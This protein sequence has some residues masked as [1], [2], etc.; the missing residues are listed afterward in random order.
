MSLVF[1]QSNKLFP[2][3]NLEFR[4]CS[5]CVLC[6]RIV[7]ISKVYLLSLRDQNMVLDTGAYLIKHGWKGA[8]L[9]ANQDGREDYVKV[10]KKDDT[11]G[12][13]LLFHIHSLGLLQVVYFRLMSCW[14]LICLPL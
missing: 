4:L 14:F 5:V 2:A 3:L 13:P 6:V 11:A 9:G 1:S 8:G 10:V 7:F 12:V